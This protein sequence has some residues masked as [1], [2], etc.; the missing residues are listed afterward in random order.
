MPLCDRKYE[1]AVEDTLPESVKEC[2][3]LLTS[4][5]V[6]LILSNL[7][8]LKLHPLAADDDQSDSEEPEAKKAKSSTS[9]GEIRFY[10]QVTYFTD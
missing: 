1:V 9:E 5:A 3:N 7:T 10:Q 8:G 4:D 2:L 6:F